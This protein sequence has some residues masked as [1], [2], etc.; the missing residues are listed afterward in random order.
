MSHTLEFF[1]ELSRRGHQPLLQRVQATIRFEVSDDTVDTVGA[2]AADG[3]RSRRL[4]RQVTVDHGDLSISGDDAAADPTAADVTI[5]CTASELDDLVNGR[6]SAMAS[7]LRGALTVQGDPELVVL[8][9]RLFSRSPAVTG[10]TGATGATGP[11]AGA[12]AREGGGAS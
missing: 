1:D 5:T 2:D 7:L 10:A 12:R 8:A 11:A 4:S 6:T 3:D 9:Q